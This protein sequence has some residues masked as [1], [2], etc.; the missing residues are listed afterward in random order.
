MSTRFLRLCGIGLSLALLAGPAL[1][2]AESAPP[3]LAA[4]KATP[5]S[6]AQQAWGWLVSLWDAVGCTID[7]NGGCVP[8]A[9]PEPP[10]ATA[11][12]D[13]GEIGC[14]ADPSGCPK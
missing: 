13:L 3:K 12:W 7:P 8:A 10:S 1:Q 14:T 5:A 2:A 6:P 11:G 9:G 4:A